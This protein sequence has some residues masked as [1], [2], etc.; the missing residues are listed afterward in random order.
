SC[1]VL[2]IRAE[3]DGIATDEDILAFFARLPN[4]DKQLVKIG[5]LAHTAILGVNRARFW[6]ALDSFLSMP[7][8][9]DLHGTKATGAGHA[10]MDLQAKGGRA[11]GTGASSGS[12][13][14][15]ALE[16][17][18]EGVGLAITGRRRANLEEVAGQVAAAGTPKPVVIVHEALDDG[19]VEALAS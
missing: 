5:G 17:G 1:P 16:L 9:V 2:I 7:A 18:R 13:R 8:R 12:G 4:A 14:A 3:H 19:Y 6:H 10:E 15:M 11:L